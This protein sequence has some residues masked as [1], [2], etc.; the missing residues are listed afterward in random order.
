ME[1][2]HPLFEEEKVGVSKPEKVRIDKDLIKCYY[3]K[4]ENHKMYKKCLNCNKPLVVYAP[5]ATM[6]LFGHKGGMHQQYCDVCKAPLKYS[7]PHTGE[8]EPCDCQI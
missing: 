7:F 6:S 5:P 4:L 3:C 2:G 1:C 8:W